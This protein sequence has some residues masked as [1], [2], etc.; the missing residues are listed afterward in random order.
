M[1]FFDGSI[2]ERDPN[3]IM[4]AL[5]RIGVAD[6]PEFS[7]SEEMIATILVSLPYIPL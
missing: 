4:I 3:S 2:A 7:L 6:V 5:G 1:C